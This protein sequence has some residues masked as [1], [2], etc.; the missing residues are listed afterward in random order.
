MSVASRRWLNLLAAYANFRGS[1]PSLT[2]GVGGAVPVFSVHLH[3]ARGDAG[4]G[5]YRRRGSRVGARPTA[6][7]CS[8]R[9]SKFFAPM[10]LG[11]DP[12][13]VEAIWA[14]LYARS[15]DYGQKGVMLAGISAIDI[16][17]WDIKAQ[18]AGQPLYRLLGG[19]QTETIEC[20]AT[21]FYFTDSEPLEDRFEK[22]AKRYLADGFR[23]MKVKVGLGPERDAELI[24]HVRR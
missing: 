9:R 22:E 7:P 21:G 5:L 20:Y 11:R 12:R 14:Y 10:L 8:A 24:R 16:A 19:E 18:A 15:V 17:L 3:G 23:A 6:R 4:R 13:D 1:D 2:R